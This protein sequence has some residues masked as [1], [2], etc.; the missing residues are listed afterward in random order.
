MDSQ[1]KLNFELVL[2]C[3]QGDITAVQRLLKEGANPCYQQGT[4]LMF[5]IANGHCAIVSFL[6]KHDA[7]YA[8]QTFLE[9]AL[10]LANRLDNVRLGNYIEKIIKN[11]QSWAKVKDA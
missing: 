5:A 4:P 6:I 3:G 10:H 1:K 9:M 2:Q 8:N 11:G 7:Y